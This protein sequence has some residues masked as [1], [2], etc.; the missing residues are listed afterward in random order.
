MLVAQ[1]GV[2]SGRQGWEEQIHIGPSGTQ[3]P[4]RDRDLQRGWPSAP[5]PQW[6]KPSPPPDGRQGFPAPVPSDDHQ[7][8]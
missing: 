8:T 1:Q 3:A 2:G 4:G 6:D 7:N 5:G